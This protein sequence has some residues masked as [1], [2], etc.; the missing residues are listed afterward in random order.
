MQW[1]DLVGWAGSIL[2]L[3]AFGLN[4]T[5][6]ICAQSATYQWLNILGSIF[7][8]LNTFHYH[9][10]PSMAVNIIWTLIALFSFFKTLKSPGPQKP[11]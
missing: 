6:R 1:I 4:S 10:F 3:L 11:K 9:A 8:I 5:G 7:L 2:V